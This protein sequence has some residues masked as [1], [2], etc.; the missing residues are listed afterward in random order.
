MP[1]RSTLVIWRCG[2]N[3]FF[4]LSEEEINNFLQK[5]KSDLIIPLES[6][7]FIQKLAQN[8]DIFL[9]LNQLRTS[10]QGREINIV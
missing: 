5:R 2:V 9:Q 4:S 10:I 3:R 1:Y 8:W 6:P 7:K